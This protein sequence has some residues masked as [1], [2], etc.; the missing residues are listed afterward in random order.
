MKADMMNKVQVILLP[1]LIRILCLLLE[2]TTLMQTQDKDILTFIWSL[3]III[4]TQ[5]KKHQYRS[6]LVKKI[7][8]NKEDMLK[9]MID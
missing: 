7:H 2:W 6:F 4:I 3:G 9:H 5:K 8:G 1:L